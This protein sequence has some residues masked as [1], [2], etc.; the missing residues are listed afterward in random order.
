[1]KR[2]GVC[3]HAGKAYKAI[4]AELVPYMK[5]LSDCRLYPETQSKFININ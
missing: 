3:V 4:S 2:R 5:A 1:M